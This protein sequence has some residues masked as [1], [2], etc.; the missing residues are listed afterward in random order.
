MQRRERWRM[1]VTNQVGEESSRLLVAVVW[2]RFVRLRQHDRA[3]EKKTRDEKTTKTTTGPSLSGT[4]GTKGTVRVVF[5]DDVLNHDVEFGFLDLSTAAAVV[6]L[7]PAF[8]L[9]L[10]EAAA[11][12]IEHHV[13][14]ARSLDVIPL[15][16]R[17]PV[18]LGEQ[19]GRDDADD[20]TRNAFQHREPVHRRGAVQDR[21]LLQVRG[22]VLHPLELVDGFH[23]DAVVERVLGGRDA[24]ADERA[25]IVED[26]GAVQA[27]GRI[28]PVAQVA[29][30]VVRLG[31]GRGFPV[32][33]A[34]VEV[35]HREPAVADVEFDNEDGFQKV[36]LPGLPPEARR[37]QDEPGAQLQFGQLLRREVREDYRVVSKARK[38]DG[39]GEGHLGDLIVEGRADAGDSGSREGQLGSSRII[40]SAAH[41][42]DRCGDIAFHDIV[43]NVID[44]REGLRRDVVVG[45][46]GTD[47]ETLVQVIIFAVARENPR[48]QIERACDG[49]QYSGYVEYV[50]HRLRTMISSRSK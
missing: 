2:F 24:H 17:D 12:R 22:I 1:S 6:V 25:L 9:L 47:F 31:L 43:V 38:I 11:V 5:G 28:V 15:R 30:D 27:R 23:D 42:P 10:L 21:R 49:K 4:G 33:G 7:E 19:D 41:V 40:V 32:F 20:R 37:A 35:V 46:V 8:V 39:E 48:D 45:V 18:V 26:T 29:D 50:L 16:K 34:H 44:E 3:A 14:H 36:H 13:G